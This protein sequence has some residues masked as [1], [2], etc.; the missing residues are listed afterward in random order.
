[1]RLRPSGGPPG[2]Q[3]ETH[4]GMLHFCSGIAFIIIL[5]IYI[6]NRYP[7]QGRVGQLSRTYRNTCGWL[8]P[9]PSNF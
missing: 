5:Y 3:V 2:L 6:H 4:P 1:M 8:D 7:S 9:Q